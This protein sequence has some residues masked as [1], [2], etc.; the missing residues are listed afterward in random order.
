M[1]DRDPNS[2]NTALVKSLLEEH[3][4]PIERFIR[5]R[6]GPTVLKRTTLDDLYQDTVTAAIESADSFRYVDDRRFVGWV[7]TIA[8]RTIARCASGARRGPHILRIRGP[9][10]SGVGV[11]EAQLDAHM[12]TPS[13][14]VAGH[15]RRAG[16]ADAIRA[17]PE[18]YCRVL[19]LYKLEERP[20]SEVAE[21]IGRTKGATARLIARSLH[22]LRRKM[23]RP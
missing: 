11:A 15:E 2:E 19:T 10:S 22:A 20:L 8:R 13:S 12:R 18:H 21:I 9:Y 4:G 7:C 3:R 1:V 5:A 14:I 23:G 16:L 17:L 6:S